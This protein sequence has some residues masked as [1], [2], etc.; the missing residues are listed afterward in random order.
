MPKGEV[1][2]CPF[3]IHYFLIPQQKGNEMK[4]TVISTLFVTSLWACGA[5][6][7]A[8]H[9]I[10]M[11]NKGID[12]IFV[13]EPGYLK[14]A[15]GD[16]VNFLPIDMAH[17]PQSEVT[18]DGSTWKG[19][20]NK[21]FSITLSEE[22]VFIYSCLPHKAL[23]MVGV[24]QVGEAVNLAAAKEAAAGI[25]IAKNKDRLNQYLAKVN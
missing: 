3:L 24:I 12:G 22:G 17:M 18:P 15:K 7:A 19:N 8:E 1:I 4:K 6:L 13:F 5:A 25:R 16:T 14:V 11:L 23:G 9:E 2:L 20:I 10:K 21:P